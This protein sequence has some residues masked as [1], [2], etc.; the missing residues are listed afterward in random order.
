MCQRK[1]WNAAVKKEQL[2]LDIAGDKSVSI[3]TAEEMVTPKFI[4]VLMMCFHASIIQHVYSCKDEHKNVEM[5]EAKTW[6]M[7]IS[8]LVAAICNLEK[9]IHL[10]KP[11]FFKI[12]LPRQ[13]ALNWSFGSPSWGVLFT[14]QLCNTI[15]LSC[16][17]CF[18]IQDLKWVQRPSSNNRGMSSYHV[19]VSK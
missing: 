7:Q 9:K 4:W 13:N 1:C 8:H 3:H 15:T 16:S 10:L 18:L 12:T 5:H 6:Q 17:L 11:C 2:L 19:L 14:V